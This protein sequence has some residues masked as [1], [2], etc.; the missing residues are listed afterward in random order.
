MGRARPVSWHPD[1]FDSSNVDLSPPVN[2]EDSSCWNYSTTQVN[3]LITPISYPAM[4]EP[5]IQEFFTPLDELPAQDPNSTYDSN[6][7]LQQSWLSQEQGKAESYALSLYSH[8]S[9]YPQWHFNQPMT[10]PTVQTAPS[11][12][13][14]PSLHTLELDNLSLGLND[15]K[16][17][18][19]SEE[20]VGMGLY[21]SPA[22]I[23][24]SSILFGG[25][26]GP[27]R[28]GLKLEESFEPTEQEDDEDED[29][30]NDDDVD[31]DDEQDQQN[32]KEED[33]DEK[34]PDSTAMEYN[35]Q[36][37]AA[38]LTY[39]IQP[40]P[41]PLASKYLATLR[42]MNSA[43]YPSEYPGYGQGYEWI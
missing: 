2:P 8:Q 6:Q 25:F 29:V 23:Q 1:Y 30:E 27:A 22:E 32:F 24:S 14:Y 28:K 13:D 16:S 41:E 18:D 9:L 33:A 36:S 17:K 15:T 34:W 7:Y 43:Y 4:N 26:T 31:D 12:P 11:S 40:E 38:H 10:I 35:S 21:D 20:L 39:G 37:I 5:Q 42:Q 3:G 19:D